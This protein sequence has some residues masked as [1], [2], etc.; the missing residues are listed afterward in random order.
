MRGARCPQE[1]SPSR[2][3][4]GP[5]VVPLDQ[6][7]REAQ[8]RGA[9]LADGG[10]VFAGGPGAGKRRV[11]DGPLRER[12]P[13]PDQ[14]LR[15]LPVPARGPAPA[16]VLVRGVVLVL[17]LAGSVK[18]VCC[19]GRVTAAWDRGCRIVGVDPGRQLVQRLSS[20]E[21]AGVAAQRSPLVPGVA[22]DVGVAPLPIQRF[23]GDARLPVTAGPPRRR[24]CGRSRRAL[25]RR[26]A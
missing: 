16:V 1:A 5:G 24:V 20:Q 12:L 9:P 6:R 7:Q 3:R 8:Q 10:A 18:V 14:Q 19:A 17:A 22:D 15:P 26:V 21:P 11:A 4:A 25:A 13:Q 2:D 23:Q